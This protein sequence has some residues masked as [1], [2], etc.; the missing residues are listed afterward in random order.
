MPT[1][2]GRARTC[3]TAHYRPLPIVSNPC[4]T[5][6]ESMLTLV[7][8]SQFNLFEPDKSHHR[9]IDSFQSSRLL[10]SSRLSPNQTISV[11]PNVST[12]KPGSTCK[13]TLQTNKRLTVF[14]LS[15]LSLLYWW[16]SI[17]LL[18]AVSGQISTWNY[19]L[20][21]VLMVE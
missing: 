5:L 4:F 20:F 10:F 16:I 2:L 13:G 11:C 8:N 6:I 21:P 14:F 15:F 17:W 1:I 3:T 19:S 7:S 18:P 9:L 12:G